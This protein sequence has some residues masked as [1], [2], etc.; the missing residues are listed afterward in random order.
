MM[1]ARWHL[2]R[3]A[4]LYIALGDGGSADDQGEG[5]VPDGNGQTPNNILGNVLRIDPLGNNSRNGEYGVPED[6]PFFTPGDG[7]FGGEAGC[8]DDDVC[9]EILAWG[10]RN[11]FRMSFDMKRGDLYAADVGQNDIEEIDVVLAGGNY[12]WPIKEGSFCFDPNGDD[13]GFVTDESCGTSELIDPVAEYDHDEG[14]AVV[15]GFEYR[16]R[17]IR[18]L[19]GRY[20]F[21]DFARNFGG[22][23]GRLFFLNKRDIVKRN[24]IKNSGI[25]ELR[26][27][28]DKELN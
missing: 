7:P 5:H 25:S 13:R 8:D 21:G 28:G 15:G 18:S 6:N 3:T 16:G 17:D 26:L 20:V 9:D 22:N 1:A 19:R 10:F 11:P 24:R 23:N 12:G 2:V 4:T 27:V 14:I